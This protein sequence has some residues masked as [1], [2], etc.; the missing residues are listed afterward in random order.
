MKTMETMKKMI[1]LFRHLTINLKKKEDQG[2]KVKIGDI[3]FRRENIEGISLLNL[4]IFDFIE[5]IIN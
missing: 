4:D 1:I 5:F 2:T 3:I